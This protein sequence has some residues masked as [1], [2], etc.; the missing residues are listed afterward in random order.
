L[1]ACGAR[2]D[3]GLAIAAR[4]LAFRLFSPP[5]LNDAKTRPGADVAEPVDAR[6][7]KSLGGNP[8]RVR[9]PPSAPLT[10]PAFIL[11]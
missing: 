3:Q 4:H 7:L 8:V 1:S 10:L 5:Q 9:V 6:D 2:F 11:Q